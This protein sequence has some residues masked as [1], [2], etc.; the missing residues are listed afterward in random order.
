MQ[1]MKESPPLLLPL[2]RSQTHGELLAWLFLHPEAE[3]STTDLARLVG[4]SQ[5]TVSREA[6]ALVR[7]GLLTERRHGRLR[8][9]RA[10]GGTAVT[11]PLT[12]LL[13]VTYGPL[14]VLTKALQQLDGVEQAY[15]Y[16]SW[17]ARYQGEPGAIPRDVDV[18]VIGDVDD[19]DLY[20]AAR[21]TQ[22]TLGREVNV[23][24]VT[25]RQWEDTGADD[26]FL[27]TVRSRPLIRLNLSGVPKQ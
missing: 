13:A 16:G 11:R 7:A 2:L 26:P 1:V 4:T 24:R 23:R 14:P 6:T 5:A 8:L 17:A 12:D 27:S 22:S 3:Y 21:S 25:S 19:D 18:L 15:I 9:L 20:E 10:A